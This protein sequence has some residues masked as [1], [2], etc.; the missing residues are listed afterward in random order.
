[1]YRDFTSFAITVDYSSHIGTMGRRMVE[2]DF[3]KESHFQ[4]NRIL[5][6]MGIESGMLV[7][8]FYVS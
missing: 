6:P 4:L 1:M 3:V 2:K 5:P 7:Y 8:R